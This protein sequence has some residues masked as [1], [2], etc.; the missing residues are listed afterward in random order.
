VDRRAYSIANA[1]SIFRAISFSL[2]GALTEATMQ[3]ETVVELPQ[4]FRARLIQRADSDYD[5]A[6]KLFNAMID[7]RPLM[8]AR[9]VDVSDVVAAVDFGRKHGLR[10]A[11]RG[12]GHNGPGLGSV[13]DGLVI[14]LSDMKGIRVDP[15]SRTVRVEAAARRAMSTT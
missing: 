8:I 11:V 7:K 2:G 13:D 10:V 6:R 3:S 9:C 14:D 15:A 4:N 12:G 1:R 5:E